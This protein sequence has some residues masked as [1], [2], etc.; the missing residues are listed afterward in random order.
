MKKRIEGFILGALIFGSVGVYAAINIMANEIRYNN[1]TVADALNDLYINKS[2]SVILNNITPTTS[3]ERQTGEKI[4][5]L[6]ITK[7]VSKGSYVVF[8]FV[9]A[10]ANINDKL[11]AHYDGLD[12]TSDYFVLNSNSGTCTQLYRYYDVH[13]T[14]NI[15][16]SGYFLLATWWREWKCDFT[17]DDTI[18]LNLG[19]TYSSNIYHPSDVNLIVTKLN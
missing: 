13:T 8:A 2:P 10:A 3:I 12:D 17:S 1:T 11:N 18:T 7:N 15:T 14:D 16:S 5:P 9:D 4:S 6:T 19:N